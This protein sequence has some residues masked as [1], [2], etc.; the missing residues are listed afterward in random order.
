ML[1]RIL[2]LKQLQ[3]Q[4]QLRLWGSGAFR[5]CS[6][7][8]SI[9][10]Q[11]SITELPDYFINNSSSL[12]TVYLPSSLTSIGMGAFEGCTSLSKVY[13][14]GTSAQ[15]SAIT[16]EDYNTPLSSATVTYNYSY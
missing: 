15:W 8:T 14:K 2:D 9:K 13:F 4:H 12:T 6:N 11:S 10:V 7:L 1:L 5:S 3:F 16:I